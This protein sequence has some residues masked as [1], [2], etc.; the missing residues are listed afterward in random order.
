MLISVRF[1][2]SAEVEPGVPA[3]LSRICRNLACE[4]RSSD[5]RSV[6]LGGLR[7][8]IKVTTD[9]IRVTARSAFG[10]IAAASAVE[11]IAPDTIANTIRSLNM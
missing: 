8:L 5:Q 1:S 3:S 11:I 2:G 9:G 6:E 4:R 7:G 10:T